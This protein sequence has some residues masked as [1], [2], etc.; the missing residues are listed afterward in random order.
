MSLKG[1][2]HA[3]AP[4][5]NLFQWI[6]WPPMSLKKGGR[7]PKPCVEQVVASERDK[8]TDCFL[9]CLAPG[10]SSEEHGMSW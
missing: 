8:P 4:C 1:Y 3:G 9:L 7:F 2:H 10:L 6:E 5:G